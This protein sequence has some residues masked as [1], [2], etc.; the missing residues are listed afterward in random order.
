MSKQHAG[1][2]PTAAVPTGAAAVDAAAV[3]ARARVST[4]PEPF[5]ARVAGRQN[6]A[7]ERRLDAYINNLAAQLQD[8]RRG[9]S[10]E[11]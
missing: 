3:P 2:N 6:R 10:G 7:E 9:P 4:H 8:E 1:R 11:A 5:L